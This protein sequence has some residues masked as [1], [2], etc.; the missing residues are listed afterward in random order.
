MSQN[1]SAEMSGRR[2]HL[3]LQ[4]NL[5]NKR[6]TTAMLGQALHRAEKPCIDAEGQAEGSALTNQTRPEHLLHQIVAA[7]NAHRH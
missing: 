1:M 6:E 5:F 7:E 3:D 4:I 2:H